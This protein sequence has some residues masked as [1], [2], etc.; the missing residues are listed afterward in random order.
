MLSGINSLS[1]SSGMDSFERMKVKVETLESQAEI[2][3]EL[4]A[5]SAGTSINL[6]EKFRLL[7][8]GSKVDEELEALKR[9]LPSGSKPPQRMAELPSALDLE[10]EKLRKELNR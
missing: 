6:E 10:Y 9:Q 7:E 5:S 1:G 8:G 4:A 3:G 2:A